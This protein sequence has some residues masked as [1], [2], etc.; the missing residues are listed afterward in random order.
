MLPDPG[1]FLTVFKGNRKVGTAHVQI[2]LVS[3]RTAG[4][5]IILDSA[6][7]IWIIREEQLSSPLYMPDMVELPYLAGTFMAYHAGTYRGPRCADLAKQPAIRGISNTPEHLVTDTGRVFGDMLKFYREFFLCIIL[8]KLRLQAETRGGND[9]E[10]TPF[11]IG[12]LEY[13]VHEILGF[14]VSLT[15]YGPGD[16]HCP[17]CVSPPAPAGQ[18]SEARA[19]YHPLRTLRLPVG[20]GIVRTHGIPS[21]YRHAPGA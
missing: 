20:P 1:R 12:C 13:L 5:V 17:P 3:G 21:R 15:G 11:N 14:P 7:K 10:T 9:R 8:F 6:D 4:F 19:G 16:M 18:A 2:M